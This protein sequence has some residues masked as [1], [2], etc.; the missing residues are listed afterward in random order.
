LQHFGSDLNKTAPFGSWTSVG[1][2]G[3]IIRTILGLVYV[4][5]PCL[6]YRHS[7]RVEI[8]STVGANSTEKNMAHPVPHQQNPTLLSAPSVLDQEFDMAAAFNQ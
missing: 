7:E 3:G 1:H 5:Q 4:E 6:G 2:W 8:Y